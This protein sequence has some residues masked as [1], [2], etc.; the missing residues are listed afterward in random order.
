M[1]WTCRLDCPILR[2]IPAHIP[3][4]EPETEVPKT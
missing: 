2:M 4:P 3:N 1:L